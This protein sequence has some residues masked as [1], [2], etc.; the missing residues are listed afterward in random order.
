MIPIYKPDLSGNEKKYVNDCL[1]SSWISSKGKYV[2]LF[3]KKFSDITESKFAVA[4]SNGTVAIHL[5]LLALGIG[6]GDEV[7]VPSLTYIA[8]VNPILYCGAKPVFVDC[9]DRDWN[10]NVDNIEEKITKRTKAIMPVHLYGAPVWI[11]EI[12]EIANKHNLYIIEDCAEAFGSTYDGEGRWFKVG[13]QCDVAT[14]S[15]F[16]NKTVTTGEG[17]MVVTNNE[18]IYNRVQK[19]KG[20]GLSKERQYWHDVVG[21]N[22]RMTNIAC[23]IGYAQ[24]ERHI[25]ILRRKREIYELYREQWINFDL[26]YVFQQSSSAAGYNSRWLNT[27][28]IKESVYEEGMRDKLMSYLKDKGIETR[29]MFYPIHTMPMYFKQ[30]VPL[31]VCENISKRGLSLP[32]YPLLT[33]EEI[34]IISETLKKFFER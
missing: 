31:P 3:E 33:D 25:E 16:G 7:I 26:P 17:G 6:K 32:S 34:G 27:I 18:S 9:D 19:L 22:Y 8:S 12:I 10:I 14:Y 23:A 2:D 5:A 1:D 24:L 30:Y 28:V 11:K 29:P 4:C 21:Y 13:T 15:F 20:Q